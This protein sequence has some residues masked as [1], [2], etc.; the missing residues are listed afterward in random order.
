MAIITK[1]ITC[2]TYTGVAVIKA[3]EEKK[4]SQGNLAK[5][6]GWCTAKQHNKEM[7]VNFII[8]PDKFRAISRL[9]FDIMQ[10]ALS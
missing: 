4:W 1:E 10:E 8:I 9:D 7:L 3:R 2:K 5:R 6:C